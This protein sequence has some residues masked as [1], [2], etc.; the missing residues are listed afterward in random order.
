MT[1]LFSSPS[2]IADTAYFKP[3]HHVGALVLFTPTGQDP[4]YTYGGAAKKPVETTI[5]E[6]VVINTDDP[7]DSLEYKDAHIAPYGIRVKL[8]EV[9]AKRGR[10]LA[11]LQQKP[12]P[13]PT[14]SGAYYLEDASEAEVAIARKYLE[15]KVPQL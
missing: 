15:S 8:N 4:A 9:L 2:S 3:S 1:D 6:V 10:L 13:S 7:S 5:S 14:I 12:N 11:R